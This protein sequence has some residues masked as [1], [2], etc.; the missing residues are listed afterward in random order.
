MDYS[1]S[2]EETALAFVFL[3]KPK[4]EVRAFGSSHVSRKTKA[5]QLRERSKILDMP[6]LIDI[7]RKSYEW[8]LNEGLMEV[9]RTYLQFR[10]LPAT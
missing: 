7:Q 1:R 3:G 8:F 10:I 2:E 9:F 6:N 5:G 4:G